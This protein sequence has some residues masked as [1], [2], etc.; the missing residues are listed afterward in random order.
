MTERE[1][2]NIVYGEQWESMTTREQELVR[3][4]LFW[5]RKNC[6]ITPEAPSRDRAIIACIQRACLEVWDIPYEDLMARG[7][8][9]PY[10]EKRYIVFY[11]ARQMSRSTNADFAGLFPSFD[12]VTVNYHALRTASD[13]IHNNRAFRNEYKR[14][15][16]RVN[17]L[18][19][20]EENNEPDR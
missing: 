5:M 9:R 1:V 4:L 11:T 17:Q 10:V 7:R 18:F 14:F 12:R 15:S 19:S 8:Q 13:L 6:G 20:E 2:I 16:E 3:C